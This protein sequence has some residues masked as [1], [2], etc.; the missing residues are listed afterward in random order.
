[1]GQAE[2]IIL[3]AGAY[4]HTSIA[5]ADALAAIRIPTIE[6]HISNVF[7]REDY[8]KT[9][10]IASRCIGSIS[11]LGMNSYS[12]AVRHFLDCLKTN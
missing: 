11:G 7:A 9:S 8:R 2:G 3:N 12:L 4:T 1:M 6:V 5:L 10:Y